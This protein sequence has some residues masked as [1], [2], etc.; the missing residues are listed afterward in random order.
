ML[1]YKKMSE[2]LYSILHV[3]LKTNAKTISFMLYY[4]TKE[5]NVTE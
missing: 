2:M 5:N 1:Y 4:N 3:K